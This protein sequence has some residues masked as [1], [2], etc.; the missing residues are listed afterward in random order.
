MKRNICSLM[1]V[2]GFLF[3][4]SSC[5]SPSNG[6]ISGN[7]ASSQMGAEE[8]QAY[9]I[10]L[11]AKNS[12]AFSGTYEEWLATIRGADG[13]SILSGSGIPS[14]SLGKDGDSYVDTSTW[15]YYLKANGTWSKQGNFA[16]SNAPHAGEKHTVTYLLAGGAMPTGR[17]VSEVVN[18]GD[19]INLP[20]PIYAGYGF[21][22]WFTGDANNVNDPLRQWTL[23]DAVFADL[24]L[25]AHWEANS[26]TITFDSAGGSISSYGN[27]QTVKYAESYSLPTASQNGYSFVGWYDSDGNAW[28]QSGIWKRASDLALT[29]H[30]K[31]GTVTLSLWTP[32]GS[33]MET[34]LETLVNQFEKANPE[35]VVNV[36]SQGGYDSLKNKIFLGSFTQTFPSMAIDVPDDFASYQ[37]LGIME[38]LSS[39]VDGS[40]DSSDTTIAFNQTDGLVSDYYSGLWAS[41]SKCLSKGLYSVPFTT[42][43]EMLYYNKNIFATNSYSVP[44]SWEDLEILMAK[45][46]TDY[47]SDI[48]L[49]YDSDANLFITL[50]Q[51][52]GIPYLTLDQ[53][54]GTYSIDFNNVAAKAMVQ[55]IK[56]WYD[57][58]YI[59][60]KG[61]NGMGSYSSTAF[62]AGTTLM[63]VGSTGGASY[64]TSTSFDT[65]VAPLFK[66]SATSPFDFGTSAS[67]AKTATITGL[68]ANIGIFNRGSKREKV[69]AWKLYKYLTQAE[70]AASFASALGSA[71]PARKSVFATT[72]MKDY[73]KQTA[74]G[75]QKVVIDTM[76]LAESE[77]SRVYTQPTLRISSTIRD[78][79][80]DIIPNVLNGTK[81]IETAFSDAYT[82]CQNAQ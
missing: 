48:P 42:S 64:F 57:A 67:L 62:A 10:Y 41:G 44:S 17:S 55:K 71:L 22:G 8:Q 63:A 34:A 33:S 25:T 68:E 20:T 32:Y 79:V 23:K 12:G 29:A 46:K 51:Q 58:G 11:L 49:A 13:S 60:T 53:E 26:Y 73:L 72:T 5:G 65:G 81:T 70:N 1:A 21:T 54:K 31:E 28:A 30:W 66:P 16:G 47:P 2:V 36:S 56:D 77:L 74:T 59:T 3:G 19:T 9:D 82:T 14:S 7:S 4:L 45:M 35:V 15:D 18:W 43:T 78:A 50:C 61:S 76:K 52:Y 6:S 27:T 69:T 75:S 37:S 40:I 38:D 39:Y 80:N 24:T